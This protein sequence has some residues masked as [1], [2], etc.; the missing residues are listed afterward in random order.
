MASVW[1]VRG[2]GA[3]PFDEAECRRA[4]AVLA[5]PAAGCELAG[6]PHGRPTTT[7]LPGDDLDGLVEAA[8]R[9]AAGGN[10]VYYRLN[11]VPVGLGRSART[12]DVLHRRWLMV[13]CD[14]VRAEPN[15][16]DPA[17]DAEREQAHALAGDVLAELVCEQ[18][19]PAPVVVD[20]GNGVQLLWRVDLPATDAARALVK[21]CL[22]ALARR[23]DRA[24]A[25]VG[26]ECHDAPR[27]ARLPGC[28][29]RK[30]TASPE[31]PYRTAQLV[32]VPDPLELV[33]VE[34]LQVLAGLVAET[35]PPAQ[36]PPAN[37]RPHPPPFVLKSGARAAR[38]AAYVRR[39]LEGEVQR[40][41]LAV[42][43]PQEGRNKALNRAAYS[44]GGLVGAGLLSR[45]E[46]EGALRPAAL[47]RGL[48]E[49]EVEATLRSGLDAGVLKPRAVPQKGGAAQQ[50]TPARA[51][52]EGP[53]LVW[54][55]QVT[56]RKVNWL[57]RRRIPRGKLTT[58]AGMGGLG[59]TFVL[60][61]IAARV[62]QGA[63]WPDSPDGECAQE[64][65]VL[66]IAGEDDPEDT[67]VPRLIE[68]KARLDR[69]AFF[70]L[71]VLAEYQLA[72]LKVLHDALDEM[73][74]ADASL[75]IIDPPT[76]YLGDA[77]EHKNAE[78][79]RLLSPLALFA[80]EQN[81]AVVMNTHVNKGGGMKVEAAMRVMGSVAWVNAVRSASMFAEDPDDPTA[82]LYLP[83]KVNVGRKPKGLRYHI[84]AI[85][86]DRARVDWLGD[87]DMTADQAMGRHSAK[88]RGEVAKDWLLARFAEKAEWRSDDLFRAAA[89]AGVSRNAVFE[90]K[91]LLAGLRVR[92]HTSEGGD[93][94]WVWS[95]P[96]PPEGP[97]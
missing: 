11:P 72:N 60:C 91:P 2:E 48:G 94:S 58:F 51:A 81:I 46:A 17:S 87:V 24:G 16:A 56:P 93:I 27:L 83:I 88:P 30:G 42:A 6:P 59:K 74:R 41:L 61:D 53:L 78:V 50:A 45:A 8:R 19:C 9:Y 69:V 22:K 84:T 68:C 35:A 82:A 70:R 44:L 92:K 76:N 71:P 52:P 47:S 28:Q 12:A 7:C 43:G 34:Q 31:R 18:G 63:E 23:F 1:T 65:R 36:E 64:G 49:R 38:E 80:Q 15:K 97:I 95:M 89:E 96:A 25:V 75:I 55:S 26:V 77:D 90:A 73:G 21:D 20:S 54:A 10:H 85:D 40:V 3:A 57:W 62:S 32:R 37:G 5:D 67:L 4:L 79:R 29:N 14:P 86:E 13:D 39:A 33:T 66:F